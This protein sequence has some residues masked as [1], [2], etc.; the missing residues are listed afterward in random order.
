MGKKNRKGPFN[1]IVDP[2]Q[3]G[4]GSALM[5]PSHAVKE[6]GKYDVWD[7]DAQE[8]AITAKARTNDL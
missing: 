8:D 1:S 5:T 3:F 7:T 2:N 6:S 4:E